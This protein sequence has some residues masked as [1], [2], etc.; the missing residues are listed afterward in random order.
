VKSCPGKPL[1]EIVQ[2]PRLQP[3]ILALGVRFFPFRELTPRSRVGLSRFS[4]QEE[5]RMNGNGYWIAA[6]VIVILVGA[7]GF[8][9]PPG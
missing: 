8:M 7:I 1:I 5:E 3:D 2:V 6:L 9:L 4:H